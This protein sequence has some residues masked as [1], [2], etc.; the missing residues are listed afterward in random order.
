VTLAVF[1]VA[2]KGDHPIALLAQDQ[3]LLDAAA[4]LMG[5][6]STYGPA[7]SP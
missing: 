5:R 1:T 3:R 4:E 2:D 6:R 7:R